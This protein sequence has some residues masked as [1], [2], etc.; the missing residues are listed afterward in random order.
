VIETLEICIASA[1]FLTI[2]TAEVQFL[3]GK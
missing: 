1:I 3:Y 2:I